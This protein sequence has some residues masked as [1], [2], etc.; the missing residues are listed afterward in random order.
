MSD[1]AEVSL[2]RRFLAHCWYLWGLSV[3]Y[4]AAR[5]QDRSLFRAG[6]ASFGRALKSWPTFAQAYYQRGALR[7]RE[8][9]E[10]DGAVADLSRAS[11]LDPSWPEPYLQRGLLYRFNHKTAEARADLA[12]YLE[13]APE[14]EWREEAARQLAALEGDGASVV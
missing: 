13:L 9:G 7:G 12:R 14:G 2:V 8:L 5:A 11:E 4:A 1:P 3:C 6:A 10:Y